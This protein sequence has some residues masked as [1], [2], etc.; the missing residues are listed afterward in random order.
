MYAAKIDENSDSN[1]RLVHATDTQRKILGR[2]IGVNELPE[3]ISTLSNS[4]ELHFGITQVLIFG[5][6]PH[7]PIASFKNFSLA[8]TISSHVFSVALPCETTGAQ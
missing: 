6:N 2:I 5:Q 8:N 4:H 7:L 1:D 3:G